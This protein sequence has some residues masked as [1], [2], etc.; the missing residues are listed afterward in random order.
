M[1]KDEYDAADALMIARAIAEAEDI[2]APMA[3]A[4]MRVKGEARRLARAPNTEPATVVNVA[5]RQYYSKVTQDLYSGAGAGAG[6]GTG[7]NAALK[8]GL[9]SL[10]KLAGKSPLKKLAGKPP[11]KKLSG[12]P[13]AK[14][15]KRPL[16]PKSRAWNYS[17]SSSGGDR[18]RDEREDRI[19]SRGDGGRRSAGRDP[20]DRE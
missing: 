5:R 10:K 9:P 3:K 16:K 19:A 1:S 18:Q 15:P 11:L 8:P 7:A 2:G 14:K 12:R 13:H 17:S 4:L 20:A 6:V